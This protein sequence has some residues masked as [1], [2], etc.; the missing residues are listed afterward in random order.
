[1]G[2]RESYP[3]ELARFLRANKESVLKNWIASLLSKPSIRKKLP[4]ST[5]SDE[6]F[7]GAASI[8][9]SLVSALSS[10]A[11]TGRTRK[12]RLT[13]VQRKYLESFS[14]PDIQQ[15]QILLLKS[16]TASVRKTYAG[17]G[18]KVER[19]TDAL[20]DR[21]HDLMLQVVQD[22]LKRRKESASRSHNKYARLLD[23]ANDAIFLVSFDSGL[24]VEVNKAACDLT[25]Y[26]EAEL[27]GMGFN[28]LVSVFDL[29]LALERA[30]ATIEKGAVRFDDLS[31]LSKKGEPI[32]VDISASAIT[33]DGVRHILAIMRDIKER[34]HFEESIKEKARRLQL[35][36]EIAQVITFAG[37]NI[38]A[39]LASI[40]K[41]V[42]RVVKAEA[43]SVLKVEDGELV[44]M[45]A[46]GEKAEYVKPFRLKV[47]QGVAGWVAEHGT[48]AI[49][50]D[51]HKDR[52]YYPEVERA[53]GFKTKSILA[54]PMKTRDSVVGV[55]ELIN[56]VGGQFT[57]KDLDLM[58]VVSSF[59][60]V[61]L[62]HARVHSECQHAR[63]RLLEVHSPVSASRL[64]GV[65]AHEMKDPLG[66]IKNYVRILSD[67]LASENARQEELGVISEEI[68]RITK[69]IDQLLHFS[70]ACSE[71]PKDT[72]L[73][74]LVENSVESMWEALE[75][76]RIETELK[77]D[78]SLPDVRVVP[79]QMKM[80]FA[81]LLRLAASEMPE[82]GTLTVATRHRDPF[83][84][85]EFSNTGQRHTRMEGNELFLPSAVA[86]G[87][88]PK[89]LGLY[90]VYNIIQ[91]C[92]GEIEVRPRK[93]KGSTYRV[94]VPLNSGASK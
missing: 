83:V 10:P 36:N 53:T 21:M 48:G 2:P 57:K 6:L 23:I 73:N 66:I 42:S 86:K 44:F 90:M 25:G 94:K 67:R 81:S 9:D 56:K 72:P 15:A 18:K 33:V 61:A 68:D 45:V 27:K 70:E 80:V 52:R 51:A 54:V 22:D 13:Q 3:N 58:T 74:L 7:E 29:N 46:L 38:E 87:L 37:L 31:I 65:V 8:Y 84:H 50:R 34:K 63:A 16:L 28:S 55:I 62:E 75:Q 71:A 1:M 41:G 39:V 49:V 4:P 14:P 91:G 78:A 85:I 40:L 89:G 92:G 93:G 79:S 76:A 82:G 64:A 19:F 35:V 12:I 26:S 59:A 30:N 60:A 69:I 17:K 20:H 5:S 47:G 88:V 11:S 77:L 24:F 32:P 43:G